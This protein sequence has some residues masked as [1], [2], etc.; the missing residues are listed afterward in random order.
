MTDSVPPPEAITNALALTIEGTRE[1]AGGVE[2]E[3]ERQRNEVECGS[4]SVST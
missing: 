4:T 2:R 3:R 1:R